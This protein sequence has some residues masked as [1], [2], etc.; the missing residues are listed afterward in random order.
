MRLGRGSGIKSSGRGPDTHDEP[1]RRSAVPGNIRLS[2]AG[3]SEPLKR[4]WILS[5]S[6]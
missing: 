2:A 5:P 4:A 1:E 3:Q 6:R